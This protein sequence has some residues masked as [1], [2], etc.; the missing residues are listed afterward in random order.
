MRR[1]GP[2]GCLSRYAYNALRRWRVPPR[3]PKND[4]PRRRYRK[5]LSEEVA[6]I[7]SEGVA[8]LGRIAPAPRVRRAD[9]PGRRRDCCSTALFYCDSTRRSYTGSAPW[10]WSRW[11]RICLT[12]AFWRPL[13]WRPKMAPRT[14]NLMY[15]GDQTHQIMPESVATARRR[16]PTPESGAPT[17][18]SAVGTVAVRRL[19]YALRRPAG[20]RGAALP[21][22]HAASMSAIG[23]PWLTSDAIASSR[24]PSVLAPASHSSST[25]SMCP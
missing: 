21:A 12:I 9:P 5:Y 2:S 14:R 15:L 6:Y 20:V 23:V 18:P 1:P 16:A 13:C 4:W 24:A 7:M 25:T 3:A 22:A 19:L 17:R 11:A 10:K 8:L